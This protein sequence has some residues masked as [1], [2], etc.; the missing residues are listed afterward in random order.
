MELPTT[1]RFIQAAPNKWFFGYLTIPSANSKDFVMK[2]TGGF[3]VSTEN[4]SPDKRKA[5]LSE[6]ATLVREWVRSDNPH[7]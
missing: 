4:S 5:V 2:R 1:V 3:N 7:D 6:L